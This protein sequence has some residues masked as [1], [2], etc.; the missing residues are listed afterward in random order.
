[1]TIKPGRTHCSKNHSSFNGFLFVCFLVF[2]FFCYCCCFLRFQVC[3]RLT[4]QLTFS[5]FLSSLVFLICKMEINIP[6]YLLCRAVMRESLAL[7]EMIHGTE[8]ESDKLSG[9]SD[10]SFQLGKWYRASLNS[11]TLSRSA[12]C[13]AWTHGGDASVMCMVGT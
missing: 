9:L 3:V 6:S 13:S 7:W 1:L 10:W 11:L 8:R 12:Q 4:V 2:F 5:K